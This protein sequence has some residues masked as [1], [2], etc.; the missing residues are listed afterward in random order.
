MRRLE[1]ASL[2]SLAEIKRPSGTF[3]LPVHLEKLLFTNF[4]LFLDGKTAFGSLMESI[5]P[6]GESS[7]YLPIYYSL[8]LANYNV[9]CLVLQAIDQS[10]G[11]HVVVVI[12]Q[13]SFSWRHL[14]YIS[15]SSKHFAIHKM[16]NLFRCLITAPTDT[17][18]FRR[19]NDRCG[20]HVRVVR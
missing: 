3:S 15:A 1:N 16:P 13:C 14:A 5:C 4:M 6:T 8:L 7:G 12:I 19:N 20:L 2:T 11:V 17:C 18:R 9:P 10:A